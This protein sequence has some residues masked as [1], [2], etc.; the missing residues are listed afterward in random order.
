MAS[1][2][3]VTVIMPVRNEEDFIAE[4]LGAVLAQDYPA[5]RMEILVT[6]G[7]ST[8][9]TRE[10]VRDLAAR[11][12][13]HAVRLLDNPRRIVAT[14]LNLAM[15]VARGEVIARVDGHCRIARDYLSRC[16]AHLER[17]DVEGVGGPINTVASTVCGQAIAAAMSSPFGVGDS[18]FR[19]V[20]DRTLL[21]DT[22]A[23]PAYTRRAIQ[24]AGDYDEALV[25]NQDDEYNY[26][27]RKLGGRIL[28]AADVRSDYHSRTSLPALARQ[29][30]QYGYYKVLVMRKHIRQMRAR[31]FVP[32]A[33]V[34]AILV[35]AIG[36]P[37]GGVAR[38]ALLAVLGMYGVATVAA[39]LAS[40]RHG[41]WHLLGWLL[42]AFPVLHIAYGLGFMAGLARYASSWP[43]PTNP[44]HGSDASGSAA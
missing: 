10:I 21:V 37:F 35:T 19:T 11:H 5:A 44:A 40:A 38:A 24:L 13:E 26:R 39:S 15:R 29:Y 42:M 17:G 34:S 27:L 23:F 22:V 41:R 1:R 30:F 31:Q 8:D 33:F 9:R 2:P 7:M 14:G 28:L 20:K 4:S 16:V 25:R 6:D 12:P 18:A 43:C 32:S 36:S 3:F